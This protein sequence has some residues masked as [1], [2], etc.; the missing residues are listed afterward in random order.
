[1][2][3]NYYITKDGVLRRK[4]NTVYF[5]NKEERRALPI[6]KIYSIYAYGNLSFTSGVV[7]FLA[8]NGV[9]IHFFNQY[10]FYE[11]TLYPRETLVSG[12]VTINQA[13]HH[14]DEYKRCFLA[15]KF[16][17][18]ATRNIMRNLK[19]YSGSKSLERHIENIEN[20]ISRV[21]KYNTIPQIMGAEGHIRSIYY[22]ALDRILPDE[23]KIEKRIK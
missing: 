9:P 1:M 2:K 16:V 22:M 6:N 4:E 8:K 14:L 15:K 10:G 20:E 23:F 12:D 19:Y 3:T 7:S 13:R 21:D 17:E 11:G 18:G 5:I